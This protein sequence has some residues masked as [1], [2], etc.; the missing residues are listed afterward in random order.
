M[1]TIRLRGEK[2]LN[3]QRQLA[4]VMICW[5]LSFLSIRQEI[6]NILEYLLNKS[7]FKKRNKDMTFREWFLYTRF[8]KEIPQIMLFLYVVI[9]I[10]HPLILVFCFLLYL[11]GPY[12][13]IGGNLAKGVIAF[14][15]GWLLLYAIAFWD[16]PNRLPKYSRWIKKKRGMPPKRKK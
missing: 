11:L 2:I 6:S 15:V 1:K 7:A 10:G 5:V 3:L 16:W 12:P 8:R 9:V 13:E 4:L 14:D